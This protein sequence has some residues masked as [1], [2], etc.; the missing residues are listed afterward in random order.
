MPERNGSFISSSEFICDNFQPDDLLAV[1]IRNRQKNQ[2]EQHISTAEHIVNPEFQAWLRFKNSLGGDIYVTMNPLKSDA[3]KCTAN[4]IAHVRHLY[5]DF[6]LHGLESLGDIRNDTRIPNPSYVLN[7]SEGR[8]QVIWKMIG[9]DLE[10]AEQLQRALAIEYGANNTA[11]DV[12]CALRMPGFYN[13]KYS[14]PYRVTA[15]KL[16]F[17]AHTFSEFR[18]ELHAEPNAEMQTRTQQ[19]RGMVSRMEPGIRRAVNLSIELS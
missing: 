16:G 13:H 6:D 9:H 19:K 5:L 14:L 4:N 2:S 17:L 3:R 18:I 1:V 15:E 11:T 7:T 8:Y 12:A 10:K